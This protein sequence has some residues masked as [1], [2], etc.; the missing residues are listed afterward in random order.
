LARRLGIKIVAEGQIP[1]NSLFFSL[2]SGNLDVETGSIPDCIRH[3][4]VHPAGRGQSMATAYVNGQ[5][6]DG[7][8]LLAGHLKVGINGLAGLLGQF[9]PDR[10]PRLFLTHRRTRDRI[11]IGRNVFDLECDYVASPQLAVDSYIEQ[12]QFEDSTLDVEF[13]PDR[14]Y[15]FGPKGRLGPD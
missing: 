6:I 14:P 5:V 12:C 15:V 2:L 1:K 11:P 9:E 10:T 13:G 3:H 7:R 8:G 4:A